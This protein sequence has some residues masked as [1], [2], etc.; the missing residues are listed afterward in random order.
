M[1]IA[2]VIDADNVQAGGKTIGGKH[3]VGRLFDNSLRYK[4]ALC[5]ENFYAPGYVF[6]KFYHAGL[7]ARVWQKFNGFR[8]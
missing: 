8:S 1:G 7:C 3:K 2:L 5:V 4:V 6:I